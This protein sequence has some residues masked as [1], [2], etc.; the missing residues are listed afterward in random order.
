VKFEDGPHP[1]VEQRK[2]HRPPR[3][4][5]ARV[6]LN[7]RLGLGITE[8]VGTM[9]AAY[10]FA[11]LALVSLPAALLSGSVIVIVAWIAQTFLQLILLP[12]IIVGQNIQAAPAD[13]RAAQ[14]YKDAEAILHE[15]MRL[16]RHL[17]AQD[18]VLDDLARRTTAGQ[19]P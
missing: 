3:V 19:Q 16:Q 9:R 6:G 2:D 14:T 11:A 18:Q 13:R 17:Q 8:G 15:C 7:G 12:I 10:I 4:N 1:W 5:D